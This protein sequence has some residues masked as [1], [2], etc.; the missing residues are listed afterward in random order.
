MIPKVDACADGS[1]RYEMEESP[2]LIA[3]HAI[4][5]PIQRMLLSPNKQVSGVLKGM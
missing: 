3:S 2:R 5:T 1:V 4:G